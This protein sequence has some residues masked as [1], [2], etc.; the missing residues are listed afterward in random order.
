[1]RVQVARLE[2]AS[3]VVQPERLEH[4]PERK[5]NA[6]LNKTEA[7]DRMLEVYNSNPDASLNDVAKI[8]GK[9]KSTVSGYL[10]ELEAK[11]R[12]HVNGSVLVK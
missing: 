9:G 3:Q 8:L 12:V 10:K 5:S 11:G 6:K 2:G 4:Q 7:M 1:M